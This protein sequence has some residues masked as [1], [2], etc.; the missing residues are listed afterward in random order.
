MFS[1]LISLF[2]PKS[3]DPYEQF[4]GAFIEECGRQ[5]RKPTSYDHQT[6]SFVFGD[7]KGSSHTVF[8][9]NNFLPGARETRRRVPS[10]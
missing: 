10:S 8:L 3:A 6:R 2:R 4:V 1:R 7:P 9:E 5:G